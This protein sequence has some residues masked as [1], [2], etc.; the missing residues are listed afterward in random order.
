MFGNSSSNS[1]RLF[2][3]TQLYCEGRERSIIRG[4]LHFVAC[5]SFFPCLFVNYL[6]ILF[7]TPQINYFSFCACFLNFMIIYVAH[8]ISAFYHISILLPHQ[9]MLLQK[10]DIIGANFYVASSYL[11]MAITLFPVEA[12]TTLLTMSAGV[13]GWNV[14]CIIHSK[15][16]MHQPMYIIL[17]QVLFSPFIYNYLTTEELIMNCTG[18][19]S[20]SGGAYFL[21]QID[22]RYY[23]NKERKF[24]TQFDTYHAFSVICLTT[25]CLMNYSIFK[26][27]YLFE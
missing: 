25:T 21:F 20:L 16:G 18:I 22:P 26:R 5:I 23:I 1:N 2:P 10:M 24:F 4:W 8:M 12:C 19:I 17:L 11:P 15:Y 27:T 14:R 3:N 9:E 7:T 6:N 13:L